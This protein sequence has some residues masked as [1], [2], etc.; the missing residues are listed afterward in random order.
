[1]DELNLSEEIQEVAEPETDE[2]GVEEQEAAEP[3]I[4]ETN[5]ESDADAAFAR[6]RREL[7]EA[8]EIAEERD[9]QIRERDEALGLFFE[10]ENKVAQAKAYHD[11]VPVEQ[12]LQEMETATTLEKLQLEKEKLE[13]EK[14]QI[15]FE[16]MKMQDKRDLNGKGINIEDVT[17]LGED[18]FAYRTGGLSAEQAY[19]LIQAKKG[20]PPKS[21]GKVKT[22]QGEPEYYTRE[23]VQNMSSSERRKN[24]DKVRASMQRW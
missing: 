2:S 5:V 8:R 19:D 12:V 7:E 22:G 3:V 13:Q 6:M 9:R 20:T 4:E 10:G 16:K 1:M 21:L 17:E 18:F 23:E 15:M 11:S 14:N 24:I